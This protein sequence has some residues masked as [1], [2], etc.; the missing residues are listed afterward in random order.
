VYPTLE[1][2]KKLSK[3]YN[4]IPIYK[5]LNIAEPGLLLLFK[6]FIEK[7][8]VIFLESAKQNK[9]QSRFSFLGF[10]P[11]ATIVFTPPHIIIGDS[12]S[13][14]IIHCT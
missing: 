10:N 11:Q 7:G 6:S 14:K 3:H 13:K 2:Y 1:Q 5:K 8:D 4:R 9:K 12:Y